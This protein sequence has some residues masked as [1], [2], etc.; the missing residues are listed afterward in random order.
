MQTV[1][2]QGAYRADG[3]PQVCLWAVLPDVGEV[4]VTSGQTVTLPLTADVSGAINQGRLV[5]LPEPAPAE[6]EPEAPAPAEIKPA[7][8]GKT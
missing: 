8:R 3:T 7:K 6:P 4:F 2:V 5:V 1:N